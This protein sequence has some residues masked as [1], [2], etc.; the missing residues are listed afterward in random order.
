MTDN[1]IEIDELRYGYGTLETLAGPPHAYG[2]AS[3]SRCS[4]LLA[5]ARPQPLR[6]SRASGQRP[7]AACGV[8]GLDPTP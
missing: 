5:P 7:A 2:E 4:E 6:C 1:A 3:C 8:L